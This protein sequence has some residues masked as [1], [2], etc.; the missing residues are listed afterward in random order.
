[1]KLFFINLEAINGDITKV[2]ILIKR[3]RVWNG[4]RTDT[5][6]P[7]PNPT[8]NEIRLPAHVGHPTKSPAVIPIPLTT[9]SFLFLFWLLDILKKETINDRLNPTIIE[10]ATESTKL[11]GTISIVKNSVRYTD[12]IGTY[13]GRLQQ[14]VTMN[15]GVTI[16]FPSTGMLG[17][18]ISICDK[19]AKQIQ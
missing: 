5:A 9:E 11:T 18:Y 17:S 16:P 14:G 3:N 7:D 15:E 2:G 12:S 6:T 4:A 10:I 8:K 13:P 1:V 19:N